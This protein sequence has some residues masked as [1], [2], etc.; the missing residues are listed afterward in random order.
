MAAARWI[1]RVGAILVFAS[2]AMPQRGAG[3]IVFVPA[4]LAVEFASRLPAP[5][6]F[7]LAAGLLGPALAGLALGFASLPG[8]GPHPAMRWTVVILLLASS[9]ALATLGSI[10]LTALQAHPVAGLPSFVLA[11]LLFLAPILLGGI[12]LARVLGGSEDAVTAALARA[13]LGILLAL[14]GLFLADFG[15]PVLISWLAVPEAGRALAGA[16]AAPA[17]GLLVAAGELIVLFRP[18]PAATPVPVLGA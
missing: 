5:E 15:A 18:A 7:F 4:S 11:L 13:S 2:V 12:V 14:H 17:G 10:L 3:G 8:A 6:G 9:F 16:W 1:I